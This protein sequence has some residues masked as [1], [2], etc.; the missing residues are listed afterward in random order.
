MSESTNEIV[1]NDRDFWVMGV[2]FVML[3]AAVSMMVVCLII[4]LGQARDASETHAAA[5]SYL[6]NLKEQERASVKYLRLHPNGAPSIGVS[7]GQ[8]QRSIDREQTAVN[9][10]SGLN[11][12]N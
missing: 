8:L 11:C 12:N 3:A 2:A 5:C 7:A 6:A 1:V 4:L 10:L 9:S